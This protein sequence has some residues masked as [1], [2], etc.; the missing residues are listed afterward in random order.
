[1]TTTPT[2][3]TKPTT[4]AATKPLSRVGLGGG[5]LGD[6]RLSDDDARRLVH[7]A[8]DLGVRV[9]DAARSYGR[10]EE[11]LGDALAGRN[12][13]FVATKGGYGVDGV[14]DWTLDCV[15][16]GV[17]EARRRLRRDVVDA[18]FLHSCDEATTARVADAL[19]RAVDQGLVGAAGFAGDGGPLRAAL[20]DPRFGVVECS[21]SPV[22]QEALSVVPAPGKRVL[23]KRALMNAC[24]RHAQRPAAHDVGT[25]WDRMHAMGLP[26]LAASASLPLDALSLRFAAWAPGVD[27][28]LV[29][30]SSPERL[31]RAVR[32]VAEGPLP[33]DVLREVKARFDAHRWPGMI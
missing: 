2:T 20:A 13:V 7:A 9:F 1:M 18:F 6:A 11:R 17:D 16:R 25:Y 14:P 19:F 31:A 3:A 12:D 4:P 10:A 27:C 22:D 29:G 5:P 21:V 24:F 30:T 8:L 26:A 23:A 32:V 28:V 15:A 33:D